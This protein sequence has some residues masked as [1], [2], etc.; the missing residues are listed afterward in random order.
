VLP[1]GSLVDREIYGPASLGDGLIDGLAF[2][3]YGNLWTT[4]IFADRLVAITPDGDALELMNDGDPAALARFERE[5]AS[6]EPAAFDTLLACGGPVCRWL[7]SV[8][9]G[10]PDLRTVYLGG[11]R[12]TS[13]TSFESPVAGLPMVHW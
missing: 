1:D 2:D 8:T 7:A 13:I 12:T 6:G 3:A 4:M 10:G 5:F 9:F 11:L